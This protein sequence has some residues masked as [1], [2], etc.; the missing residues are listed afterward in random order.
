MTEEEFKKLKEKG[1]IEEIKEE[2]RLEPVEIPVERVSLDDFL[3]FLEILRQIKRHR[4]TTPT[5][6]PKSFLEQIEFYDDGTNRRLY[7]YINGVWRYV[8]LT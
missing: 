5:H 1:E 7:L 8:A 4:I 2:E 6:K 3:T